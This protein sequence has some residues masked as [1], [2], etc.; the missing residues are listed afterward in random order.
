MEKALKALGEILEEARKSAGNEREGKSGLPSGSPD[1]PGITPWSVDNTNRG[2]PPNLY[3]TALDDLKIGVA[4]TEG[5]RFV[6]VS[7]ALCAM[8]GYTKVELLGL[9]SYFQ[10]IPREEQSSLAK[11]SKTRRAGTSPSSQ[12][13]TTVIRRD[14]RQIRIEYWM[15]EFD[16]NGQTQIYSFIRDITERQLSETK[17]RLLASAV[18][19]TS[20][21]ITITDSQNRF[22]FLNK[23]FLDT[24]GYSEVEV[25]GK[26]PG[27]LSP[28]DR[29]DLIADQ[30]WRRTQTGKWSGQLLNKRKD[31]TLFPIHLSTSP[32]V[33]DEGNI[34]G[35]IGVGR[36]ITELNEAE[37][38]L[39]EAEER[40]QMLFA[41][42]TRAPLH[43]NE[44]FTPLTCEAPKVMN[45]L[46]QH[47]HSTLDTVEAR[48][49][50]V[51]NFSSF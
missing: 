5:T 18:E 7:K 34:L 39:L 8:Y 41:E 2:V 45:T 40:F 51:L 4:V 24:Y 43:R 9:Q 13:E 17:S 25:L 49:Q 50:Q 15:R 3:L 48:I 29:G 11:R 21:I 16:H 42:Q 19:S 26:G 33:D 6:H 20:E 31:G 28:G 44:A 36:D 32:I 46:A 30:I 35:Y 12:G 10:L 23:A 14:G 22:F 38:T 37:R 47:I 1:I 27:I